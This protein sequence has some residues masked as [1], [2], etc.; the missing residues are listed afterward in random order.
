MTLDI[1]PLW[2][3]IGEKSQQDKYIG[4]YYYN[5]K[6]IVVGTNVSID[7]HIWFI[8]NDFALLTSKRKI[9]ILVAFNNSWVEKCLS[10][11]ISNL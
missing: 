6:V 10:N 1:S 7:L 4:P 3:K 11:F 5:G 8:D 2:Y 9:A